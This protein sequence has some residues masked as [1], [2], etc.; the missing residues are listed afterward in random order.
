M[1]SAA[2]ILIAEWCYTTTKDATSGCCSNRSPLWWEMAKMGCFSRGGLRFGQAG[3]EVSR[4]GWDVGRI[5]MRFAPG[6]ALARVSRCGLGRLRAEHGVHDAARPLSA[7]SGRVR[8]NRTQ[9]VRPTNGKYTRQRRHPSH[10]DASAF[11]TSAASPRVPADSDAA[12]GSAQASSPDVT[13]RW[14]CLPSQLRFTL[15]QG[16]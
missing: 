14:L 8:G 7:C 6:F 9:H 15:P 4:R 3:R 2:L 12:H 10:P 1:A 5:R 11:K 13:R 16:R